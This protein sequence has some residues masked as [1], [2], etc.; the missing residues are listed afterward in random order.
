MLFAKEVDLAKGTMQRVS[1]DTYNE[2]WDI[3]TQLIAQQMTWNST[4]KQ[5]ILKDGIERTFLND[6]DTTEESFTEKVAPF[7][8]APNHMAVN[9]AEDKLLSIRDLTTKI[10]FYSQSGLSHYAAETNRQAKLATPFVT[11]VMCLLGMPFAMSTRR[12]SKI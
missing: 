9:K 7:T 12:K 1:L 2:Q 5:W 4:E 11:V 10:N 3:S 8:T 6:M